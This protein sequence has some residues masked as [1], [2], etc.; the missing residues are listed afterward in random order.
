MKMENRTGL[1]LKRL[2]DLLLIVLTIIFIG[3]VGYHQIMDLNFLDSLYMTVITLDT[4][5]FQEVKPLTPAGKIFTILLILGGVGV[6]TYAVESILMITTH[7]NVSRYFSNLGI[8]KRVKKMKNHYIICGLGRVGSHVA[9]EMASEGVDFVCIE[10]DTR[11]NESLSDRNW[12]IVEGDATEDAVLY[13]AGIEKAKGI[14]CVMDSDINNLYVTLSARGIRSD[15][16]IITRADEDSSIP[17]F[18][19]AG[20]TQV[21]SPYTLLGKRIVRSALKPSVENII[22]LTLNEPLYDFHLEEIQVE[23]KCTTICGKSVKDSEIKSKSGASIV[24][25][26][27]KDKSMINNPDPHE[28]IEQGDTLILIGTSEQLKKAK[29]GIA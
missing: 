6:L 21:I 23:T 19:R 14:I 13:K 12:V 15:L 20:A 9:E 2:R 11:I 16:S 1:P 27:K 29:E 18:Q 3:T 4:V 25:I 26:I 28:L 22:N 7:P 10:K 24:S 17:K 5:G 8:K